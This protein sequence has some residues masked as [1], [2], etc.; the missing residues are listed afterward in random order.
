MILARSY[1]RN[2]LYMVYFFYCLFFLDNKINTVV[3]CDGLK[4][5]FY[6]HVLYIS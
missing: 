1:R 2:R 3:I 4:A 6:A 5:Y